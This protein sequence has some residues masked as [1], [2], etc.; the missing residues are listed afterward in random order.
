MTS[1]LWTLDFSKIIFVLKKLKK[2]TNF[3]STIYVWPHLRAKYNRCEEITRSCMKW[4]YSGTW[5]SKD[6]SI[7][8]CYFSEEQR[9]LQPYIFLSRKQIRGWVLEN[10]FEFIFEIEAKILTG[11]SNSAVEIWLQIAIF[12]SRLTKQDNLNPLDFQRMG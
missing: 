5:N 7:P 4:R 8:T 9:L 1:K 6:E 2:N 10:L 11:Q 3:E 12:I